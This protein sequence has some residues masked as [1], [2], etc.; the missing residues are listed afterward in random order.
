MVDH[1]VGM[2]QLSFVVQQSFL[3][4]F[5]CGLKL[6]NCLLETT[7]LLFHPLFVFLEFLDLKV[8]GISQLVN[9]EMEAITAR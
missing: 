9:L 8:N 6:F 2:I 4:V 7:V 5:C 3:Q 1:C